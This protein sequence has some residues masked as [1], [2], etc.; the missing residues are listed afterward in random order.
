MPSL[1]TSHRRSLRTLCQALSFPLKEL[2]VQGGEL[3]LHVGSEC[4]P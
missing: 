1:G 2:T 4:N 3:Q